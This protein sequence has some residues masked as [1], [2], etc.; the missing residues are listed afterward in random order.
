[1]S[2]LFEQYKSQVVPRLLEE[3]KIRNRH[4]APRIE[5]IVVSMGL[6]KSREEPKRLDAALQDLAVIT[7]QKPA[8][9]RARE[10][11]AGFK[12]QKGNIVGCLVTLRGARMYEFLDRMISIVLPRIRDFRGLPTK[13][14]DG[15]GSYS[16]GISEQV[17]FPEI[18]ADKMEFVQGMNINIVVRAREKAHSQ[19]LLECM[20]V[21]FQREK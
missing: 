4:A 2:R 19:R 21:P 7:G 18:N 14:F 10:A 8:L 12:I 17:V 1:M 15:E 3:L 11:V 13:S 5:K 16:F 9:R 6:G 20:G